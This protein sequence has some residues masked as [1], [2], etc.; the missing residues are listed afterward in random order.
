MIV[1][2]DVEDLKLTNPVVTLGI[3][4]G[5]HRGHKAIIDRLVSVAGKIN[6]ESVVITFHPHP[7]LVLEKGIE[8]ISF[9]STIEEKS[10]LLAKEG[11][12]HLVII[13]FNERLSKMRAVDFVKKILVGKIGTKNLIVGYDH[14]FGYKGEGNY[15]TI[16][17]CAGSMGFL[18]E[19]VPGLQSGNNTISSSLIREALTQGRIED[20]NKWLGYN[21]FLRGFIVEGQKIGRKLGFPT[22]NIKASY[23]YKLVP[24]DGVY[25][26]EVKLY[27]RKMKA[28]L[29]IGHNP[30]VNAKAAKR[31]VE[32]NI[33]DFDED[34]YGKEI[35]IAFRYR[36]RDEIKFNNAEELARQMLIDK[37]HALSLLG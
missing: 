29:S 35:E 33:F 18:V 25:A 16:I 21:Y 20:A 7:R 1:H 26:V 10:D 34:I 15:E 11:V 22:A 19:R 36:L 31:S 4:D 9:L 37:A 30:T 24:A 17:S 3:F 27:G 8:N 23:N 5:V 2:N 28:M 12:G 14:H 6:G 13:E 32:V